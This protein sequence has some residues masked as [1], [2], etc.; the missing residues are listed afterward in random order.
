MRI[1]VTIDDGDIP[2][3]GE[4]LTAEEYFKALTVKLDKRRYK[5]LRTLGIATDRSIQ[6]IMARALDCYLQL[7]EG[8]V[9][10]MNSEA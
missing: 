2:C 7:A 3:F 4:T 6:E 9:I 10:R 8:L 5:A 1:K